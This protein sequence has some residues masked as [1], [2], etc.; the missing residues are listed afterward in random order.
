MK[1]MRAGNE[2]RRMKGEKREKKMNMKMGKNSCREMRLSPPPSQ[3]FFP[4]SFSMF[5]FCF[6]F[7]F[8]HTDPDTQRKVGREKEKKREREMFLNVIKCRQMALCLYNH[9]H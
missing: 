6:I 1:L 4:I 9:L 8:S 5:S 2:N 3:P 7:R